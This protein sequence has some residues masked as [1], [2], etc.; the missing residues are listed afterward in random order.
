MGVPLNFL[1]FQEPSFGEAYAGLILFENAGALVYREYLQV[2]LLQT[3]T[4]GEV[5]YFSINLSL[6]DSSIYTMRD[7][8]VHFSSD[9]VL[10]SNFQNLPVTPQISYDG[11]EY[12][13]KTDWM[14][15]TGE[16]I[17]LGNENFMTLGFFDDN[18]FVDTVLTGNSTDIINYD[19]CYVYI[20]DVCLSD[21]YDDCDKSNGINNPEIKRVG[22]FPN[23]A[24]DFF[25][26]D[27]SPNSVVRV[28]LF[29][30]VSFEPVIL[31][32]EE[33]NG[34]ALCQLPF[35]NDGI[36]NLRITT[37]NQIFYSNLLIL[38]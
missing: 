24:K 23:P 35:L 31:P 4:P 28:E 16:Y 20:D 36:Y 25:R 33:K 10:S 19:H 11:T 26:F 34:Y 2:K 3:L 6:A 18:T 29:N 17:A 7:F 1:G 30:M 32:V 15:I 14:N 12:F 27:M 8:S 5:Y 38:Q 37:K 21:I 13:N 9:S 22:V